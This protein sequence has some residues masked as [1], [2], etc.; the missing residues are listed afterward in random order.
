MT[1]R[2][3]LTE[4][5]V[6]NLRRIYQDINAKDAVQARDWFNGLEKAVFGLKEYPARGAPIPEDGDLRHLLY[7]RKGH[8]YRII[9]A[10]DGRNH[11]VTV[12]HI[13]HGSRAAL[14]PDSPDDDK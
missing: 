8:R 6:R 7:G 12:L 13:R 10:I 9:Y 5:A 3:D 2:V 1:Y 4:R 11:V 14:M